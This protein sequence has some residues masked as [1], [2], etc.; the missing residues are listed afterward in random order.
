M[1]VQFEETTCDLLAELVQNPVFWCTEEGCILHKAGF[2]KKTTAAMEKQIV[3]MVRQYKPQSGQQKIHTVSEAGIKFVLF[4]MEKYVLILS[5]QRRQHDHA[6][7]RTIIEEALPYIA[8][9]AGGDAVLFDSN[10]VRFKAVHADGTPNEE[11]V[12]LSNEMCRTVMREWRPSMGPSSLSP[13][14]TAVRIPLSLEYGVAFNNTFASRQRQ[15]LLNS[16]RQY[17]YARYHMEDIIG[18]SLSLT[19]AKTMAVKAAKTDTTIL[20]TGETGTG[21][22]L[23][24]QTIHNLSDRAA[25]PFVAVNC[26]AVPGELVESTLFGYAP[27]AF[28]GANRTGQVGC[29]EQADGGTIFLDEI[30]EMPYSV[31]VKLLRVLQE[32]EIIRVGEGAPRPVDVKIIASSNKTLKTRVDASKFRPDLYYRLSIFEINIPPL[33]ER[34]D[35]IVALVDF[36][37]QKYASMFGKAICDI[38]PETMR[39]LI[40]YNWPGN[41]RELRNC[42]EYVFNIVEKTSPSITPDLLPANIIPKCRGA[43]GRLS[44]YD[45]HMKQ[46]EREIVLRALRLCGNNQSEAAKRLG[47]NRTTLWRI[48]KKQ[49]LVT[50]K[51]DLLLQK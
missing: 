38:R 29:F 33:R 35:D 16:A 1:S 9:V 28:T 17:G 41:V 8:Q 39:A 43:Q 23:F 50:E 49:G 51:R 25:R 24:A 10:G 14:A 13:G 32:R 47:L 2:A 5:H 7:F 42:M 15:R 11:A 27:G 19:Q 30:S 22:E 31:Q 4:Y 18:D 40:S 21:K 48:L 6:A 37:M 36:Y 45:E 20:L 44:L 12:G 3:S 26:G 46:T 34:T